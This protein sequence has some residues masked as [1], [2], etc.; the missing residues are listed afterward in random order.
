MRY[1]LIRDKDPETGV[2]CDHSWG[3]VMDSWRQAMLAED[4]TD[5]V[6]VAYVEASDALWPLMHRLDENDR[7][8]LARLLA[9]DL[10]QSAERD[11]GSRMP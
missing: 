8:R 6:R 4:P 7:R 1:Y 9:G 5:P 10:K 11:H 2:P 3:K